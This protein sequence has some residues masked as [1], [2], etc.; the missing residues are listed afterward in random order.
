MPNRHATKHFR[1]TG[2]PVIEVYDPPE[3]WGWCYVDEVILDLSD[4]PT[5]ISERFPDTIDMRARAKRDAAATLTANA[6]R[7]RLRFYDSVITNR[8]RCDGSWQTPTTRRN[9]RRAV[10]KATWMD[11]EASD[12]CCGTG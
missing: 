8:G 5:Q 12:H 7:H 4:Q 6:D 10:E 1:A 2:H 9:F 11:P 3:G